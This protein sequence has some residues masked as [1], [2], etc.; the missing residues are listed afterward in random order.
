MKH[1]G[2]FEQHSA[3]IDQRL[4]TGLY[5]LGLAVKHEERRQALEAG[6]SAT[7]SQILTLLLAD[8]DTTPS[9]VS[10]V[11]GVSL[12]SVSDSV[13]ALV[14]KALVEKRPCP[15]HHRAT[16]L[17]LTRA[18]R[19]EARGAMRWPDFLASAIGT[20][21]DT[22][23]ESLLSMLVSLLRTLQDDG[24]IPVQRMC[25]TCTF[26]RPNVSAGSHPHHCAFVDAPMRAAHLRLVCDEHAMASV[27]DQPAQWQQFLRPAV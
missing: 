18:G 17:S 7:Q 21:S 26:F 23:Q 12:P 24:A 9:D 6:I 15:K 10:K 14:A 25:V 13:S 19:A 27:E 8:G 20:L 16:M 2:F 5:K 22:Q 11:L 4:A 1:P 3:P